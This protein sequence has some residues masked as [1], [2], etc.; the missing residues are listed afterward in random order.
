MQ[1]VC[2]LHPYRLTNVAGLCTLILH[3][4]RKKELGII[5]QSVM[6]QG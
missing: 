6:L 1:T 3:I 4:T 2:V 5:M